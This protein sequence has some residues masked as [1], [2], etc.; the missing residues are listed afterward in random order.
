MAAAQKELDAI[1]QRGVPAA[2]PQKTKKDQ[3]FNNLIQL[4]VNL[5]LK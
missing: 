3:L 4:M 2:L 1:E 5:K